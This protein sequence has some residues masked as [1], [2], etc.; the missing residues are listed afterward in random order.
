MVSS[1]ALSLLRATYETLLPLV[2]ERAIRLWAAAEAETLGKGGVSLVAHATGL[3]RQTIYTGVKERKQGAVGPEL[4]IRAPG[5]GRKKA[6]E[7]DPALVAALE[8]LLEPSVRGDPESPLRW[9]CKSTPR[10]ARELTAE[11]HPVSQRTVCRLLG[12]LGFSLQANRKTLEG[13]THPDRNAQFEF[14]AAQVAA[15]QKEGW[16]VISVDAKKK[17]LI[18]PFKNGGREWHPSGCPEEV[19]VYD[20]ADK[21]LGKVTPYGVYD[22]TANQG[23]VSVGIDHDTAE[24]A[25]ESIARWWREMGQTRYAGTPR[26]LITADGGGS[27]GSRVR[28]WKIGLQRLA[29]D[30]GMVVQVCHFPPGTS[31]WNKIEH[32]MFS[33]ISMNWRGV[34]LRSREIVIDLISH[35]TNTKGLR[36]QAG[37]DA[38]DYPKG[39][40]ITDKE[41]DQVGIEREAFHGEW[42]YRIHPKPTHDV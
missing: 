17:E 21:D 4:R 20:F 11:G 40:K 42:N 22:L 38:R 1:Q 2:H 36:I 5:G 37:L 31:K 28:L 13:G 26:L 18:G 19:N 3:S 23:W 8:A 10:L 32:R 34:P 24:F 16:P 29:T 15:F 41:L 12:D 25:V 39:R 30:L 35:T 33:H 7:K 27:N 9:T 14:I 6:R